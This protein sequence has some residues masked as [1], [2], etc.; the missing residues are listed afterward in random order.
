MEFERSVSARC[1]TFTL[2]SPEL[3]IE[4]VMMRRLH[5]DREGKG[6]QRLGTLFFGKLDFA[7]PLR[8]TSLSIASCS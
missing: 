2:K 7:R 5:A 8:I 4:P 6:G 1:S 3:Q